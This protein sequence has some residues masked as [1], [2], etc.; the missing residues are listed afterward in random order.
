[1]ERF[2]CLEPPRSTSNTGDGDGND[3]PWRWESM[4]DAYQASIWRIEP[5]IQIA[6]VGEN[7]TLIVEKAWGA[8]IELA[9]FTD[10]SAVRDM[11]L[12][13]HI[14]GVLA[15]L[16]K[17]DGWAQSYRE[18]KFGGGAVNSRLF[19]F[20]GFMTLRETERML[21]GGPTNLLRWSRNGSVFSRHGPEKGFAEPRLGLSPFRPQDYAGFK[22]AAKARPPAKEGDQSEEVDLE[23]QTT[24]DAR[25]EAR[26]SV[27]SVVRQDG[28]IVTYP[29]VAQQPWDVCSCGS[30]N[31]AD[32]RCELLT[33]KKLRAMGQSPMG[34]EKVRI[35]FGICLFV[36]SLLSPPA[37]RETRKKDWVI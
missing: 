34:Q 33:E 27:D 2:V 35:F 3:S 32:C 37:V 31:D 19:G 30:A 24:A 18:A 16:L 25:G 15:G 13:K 9:R 5:T 1:M 11:P 7:D 21:F 22:L 6:G 14:G 26:M 29:I 10:A 20:E 23:A 28:R 4:Q 12:H 8:R 36:S 17:V